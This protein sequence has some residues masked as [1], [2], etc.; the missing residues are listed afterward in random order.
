MEKSLLVDL[1]KAF[2]CIFHDLLLAKLS[3]YGFDYNSLKLI[4]CFL[5]GRKFRTKIGS[6]YSPYL[7]LLVRV[8]QGPILGPL[9]FNVYMCDLFLCDCES[10][11]INY[12]GDTTLYACEP[13]MDLVL[14]KLEKDTSTVFTWLQNNYLK[15]NS[16]NL[17]LL[18]TSHNVQHIN[19][20]GNQLSSS[21]YEELLGILIDHKLIFENHFFNIVQKIDQKLHA[22]AG[23]SKYMSQ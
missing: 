1:S 8:P 4:N 12:A 15:A 5:S 23:I 19:V 16:G 10:N 22:L 21:K 11:I 7:D 2:D 17:H 13:N 18:T 9:L 14:S 20:G 3:A 6:S